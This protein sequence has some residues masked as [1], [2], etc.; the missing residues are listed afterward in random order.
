MLLKDKLKNMT[1]IEIYELVLTKSISRFPEGF[2]CGEDGK[3]RGLECLEYLLYEKL[4]WDNEKIRKKF[5]KKILLDNKLG[6]MLHACF[7]NSP[8]KCIITLLGDTYEPWQYNVAPRNYWNNETAREAT[9]FMLKKLNWNSNDI[10]N[11]LSKET[12][13]SFGLTAMLQSVYNGSPYEAINDLM[14][15]EF[16]EWEL[17]NTPLNFWTED[18]C[19]KAMIWL[20]NEKIS[21]NSETLSCDEVRD[22]FSKN[23][24]G[25][26]LQSKFKSNVKKALSLI[27]DKLTFTLTSNSIKA[28][29]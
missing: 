18:N 26:M 14:P 25:Y 8:L 12:F 20:V 9:Q 3:N 29:F 7:D 23:G 13:K 5:C 24:L 15:G 4:E 10:K 21:S 2:W 16:N 6:G 19:K 11:N 27:E 22:I 28:S 17:K 1:T